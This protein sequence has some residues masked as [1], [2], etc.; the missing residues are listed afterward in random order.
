M[1]SVNGGSQTEEERF[2]G[3]L[4]EIADRDRRRERSVLVLTVVMILAAA[5]W[6]YFSATQVRRL[7]READ[8]LKATRQRL[9]EN[10]TTLQ[11]SL[12]NLKA[13]AN[14]LSR[15]QEDLLDFLGSVAAQESI[16][17][18]DEGV[19]WE[20]T[21]TN[22]MRMPAGTRKSVLLSAILLA[23][24]AV[25]FSLSNVGLKHGLDSPHFIELILERYGVHVQQHSG[26]RLSDAMMSQFKRVEDPLPGDLIFYRGNVGSFVVMY[27]GPGDPEG[28]GVA[29]GTLQT[30]EELRVLDTSSINTPSYPFI[31][32]FRVPYPEQKTLRSD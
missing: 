1:M 15:T 13:Q 18:L 25:P 30:G 3:A 10:I 22:L 12:K 32:Y 11:T 29:V 19:D 24:K 5:G 6:L 8:E 14:D 26:Q 7:S 21:K 20:R 27:L 23:W 2:R 17:L 4:A 16:Q 28:K 31:G 9:L